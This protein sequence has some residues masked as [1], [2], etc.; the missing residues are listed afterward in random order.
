MAQTVLSVAPASAA[1]RLWIAAGEH[2]HV[3]VTTDAATLSSMT[4][5]GSHDRQPENA[6]ACMA[7]GLRH[8]A[9]TRR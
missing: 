1:G 8:T 2:E 6:A 3:T 4:A 9:L 5:M 7:G